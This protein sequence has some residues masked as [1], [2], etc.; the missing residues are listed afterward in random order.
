MVLTFCRLALRDRH[1]TRQRR[2]SPLSASQLLQFLTYVQT[3][4]SR[5]AISLKRKIIAKKEA[6]HDI[7]F[8]CNATCFM[9]QIALAL[10][11]QKQESISEIQSLRIFEAQNTKRH[12][13]S[14]ACPL[15][16]RGRLDL[17]LRARSQIREVAGARYLKRPFS[18]H[19]QF[20]KL[21]LSQFSKTRLDCQTQK[22][23]VQTRQKGPA[24][25]SNSWQRTILIISC[26]MISCMDTVNVI[27]KIFQI[28]M[29]LLR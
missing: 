29:I 28:K 12:I 2:D 11:L 17:F 22:T 25:N 16:A 24:C 23:R 27:F 26:I 18:Y 10:R 1:K 14:D 20:S 3:I 4:S 13:A 7:N 21:F 6:I 19:T 15:Y 5:I 8:I 9:Q